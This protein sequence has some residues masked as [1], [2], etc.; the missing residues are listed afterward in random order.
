MSNHIKYPRTPHLPWS[1]GVT[2]DDVRIINTNQFTEHEVIVTEKMDGENTSLY[3][4]RCH[5]RSLDSRNHLSRDWIK[6][7]HSTIAHDI[8]EG[9]RICG[10]N[11]YAQHSVAYQKLNSYFYGFSLWDAQNNCLSWSETK[12]WF[13][14]FGIHAPPILYQGR[15]NEKAIRSIHIDPQSVEGYVVRLADQF[16]YDRFE[17]SV[18]KWVRPIHVQTDQHWMQAEI[19]PNGLQINDENFK[20]GE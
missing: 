9:W 17:Q 2:S 1:P 3:R 7:W 5:A 11:L 18:A 13:Q 8:P 15:W 6:R 12:E 14:L 10:E 16:A 19:I 4:D 20:G